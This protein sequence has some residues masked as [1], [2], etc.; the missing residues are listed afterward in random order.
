M[1]KMKW[2]SLLAAGLAC[3]MLAACGAGTSPEPQEETLPEPPVLI[4]S[5]RFSG[6]E[7]VEVNND[8]KGG[9]LYQDRTEDGLTIITNCCFENTQGDESLEDYILQVAE[10]ISGTEVQE[11]DWEE[12]GEYS[13][14][15]TY[16]VY[17]LSWQSGSEES[18]RAW[19]GFFF[20]TDTHCY[21]YGF[22]TTLDNQL[23]MQETWHEVFGQLAL[24]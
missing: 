19:D 15:F 16:P 1:K 11:L 21:F 8:Y 13:E 23:E 9:Y 14:N 17:I 7:Q 18:S 22:N 6:L 5:W 10:E 20:M 24:E 2:K 4:S 3:V 12:N